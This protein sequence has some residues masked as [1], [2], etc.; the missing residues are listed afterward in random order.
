[1]T[2]AAAVQ[3]VVAAKPAAPRRTLQRTCACGANGS[4]LTGECA[5]CGRKRV[6]G[7]QGW[8]IG[9]PGDRLEREAERAA[10]EV[11]RHAPF[12]PHAPAP[13]ARRG[14]PAASPGV[15]GGE[16]IYSQPRL[17]RA[18]RHLRDPE[19]RT[20]R[21]ARTNPDTLTAFALAASGTGVEAFIDAAEGPEPLA[22]QG[23]KVRPRQRAAAEVA[24]GLA[25]AAANAAH[26][27][28]DELSLD[29]SAGTDWSTLSEDMQKTVASL[30][31]SGVVP[32]LGLQAASQGDVERLKVVRSRLERV[33]AI[34]NSVGSIERV[35]SFEPTAF[36]AGALVVSKRFFALA[37]QRS[38]LR[39]VLAALAQRGPVPP[40][41][42]RA[43]AHFIEEAIERAKGLSGLP[44][45]HPSAAVDQPEEP[46]VEIDE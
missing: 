11:M 5:D 13:D 1:M 2:Q 7:L 25:S 30:R 31:A 26:Q 17:F 21:I 40:T 46:Q 32:A 18:L 29:V 33:R 16:P 4:A 27:Q 24:L 20:G 19:G 3:S 14:S 10:D 23:F 43:Y 44:V 35:D 22:V 12:K 8:R 15:P 34:V 9:A 39:E 36:T 6:L 28:V 41:E 42:E 45:P 37:S 38:Q